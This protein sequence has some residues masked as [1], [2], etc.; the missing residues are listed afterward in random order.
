M[1]EVWK[2][3]GLIEE[4]YQKIVSLMGREPNYL[5]LSLFGVMWSEHCSYKNSKAQLRKFPTEGPQVLQGP[6]ENAGVVDIGDGMGIAFKLESHNHP[7]AIEPYEGAA[8]GVGG[9]MRD[10]FAMGARPIAATNSLRFGDLS[11]EKNRNLLK[12]AAAGIAGYGNPVGVPTIGGEVYFHPSYD[13]NPLVNAM[14]IGLLKNGRIFKGSATGVGN[15]VMVIGA[16]TW[17]DGVGG[18]SFASEE[19]NEEEEAKTHNIPAGDPYMG[20]RLVEASLE[21]M[22]KDAVVGLQDLGAAGLTSSGSEMAGRAGSGLYIDIKKVPLREE[23]MKPWEIML[24]ETQ[25]RMLLVV[26]PEKL[27]TVLG[28]CKKW[29][30]PAA[31]IGEVTGNGNF[32]IRMGDEVLASVKAE[33][34]SDKAPVNIREW[35]EPTYFQEKKKADLSPLK[36]YE[37]W[38]ELLAKLL[39]SS[40]IM[41]KAWIYNQFDPASEAV[42]KPGSDAAVLRLPESKKGLVVSTDCNSRYTYLNPWRGGA[43][44]VAESARNV[45]CSGGKPLAITNCLN[46]GNPEKLDVYWQ[47]VQATDGI[48]EACRQFNTPV[49][50]GNVSLYNEYD[51]EAIY[52]TPTIGMIGNIEYADHAIT[53]AFKSVGDQVFLLGETLEELGASEALYLITGQDVGEVPV[54]DFQKEK[55]LQEFLYEAASGQLLQSAHDCSEGGF[56]VALAESSIQGNLG[57]DANLSGDVSEAALLFGETQGRVIVSLKSENEAKVSELLKKYSLVNQMI[58]TIEAAPVVSV[59]YNGSNIIK[60]EL[61]ELSKIWKETLPCIMG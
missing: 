35:A 34:L 31:A 49:T 13:G 9:V 53:S 52:P 29:E 33:F 15:L 28:I 42:V 26:K 55:A 48:A 3:H 45:A 4:E 7:S 50:G 20:K 57:I 30:V 47:F 54:V 24:S 25:E 27:E 2:E 11:S 58:G 61:E 21:I 14:A 12:G 44:A 36:N 16:T 39:G 51:G 40:T 17:I 56:A 5:E 23:N 1:V 10:I 32:E 59:T 41:S 46:F 19:L 6:G 22:E 60:A 18:A 38:N 43:I 8:T 37:N